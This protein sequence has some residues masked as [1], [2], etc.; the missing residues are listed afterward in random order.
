M[1]GEQKI[2][3]VPVIF[4]IGEAFVNLRFG[5]AGEAGD[6]DAVHRFA[7]LQQANDVVD[8]NP[9]AFNDGKP[10]AKAGSACDVTI[11]RADTGG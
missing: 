9:S 7:I 11:A 5:E 1:L 2:D 4:V 10:G 8:A 3:L 6:E